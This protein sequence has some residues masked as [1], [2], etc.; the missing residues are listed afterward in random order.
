MRQYKN[1]IVKLLAITLMLPLIGL[2]CKGS[3]TIKQ[4]ELQRVTLE[5]WRVFDEP[6]DFSDIITEFRKS[7]PHININVRKFRLDEYENALLRALAE[8]RGP[9]IVSIHNTWVNQYKNVIT[10]MPESITLPTTVTD[11]RQQTIMLRSQASPSL[12]DIRNNF[13]DVVVDDVIRDG[14]VYGLPLSVDT[15]ALYY[16]KA[17]LTRENI[18]LPAATW[19]D[20]K[21][22]VKLLTIQDKNGNFVQ[23]GAALG[24]SRNINRAP[25]I[26]S[27]LM[28]QNGTEMVNKSGRASFN[29]RP[30]SITDRSI[31]PG[32]DALQFYTDFASPAKEVYTWNETMPEALDAFTAQKSAYFF[33]YSYHMPLIRSL[34]PGLDFGIAPLP[35][36]AGTQASVNFANY[37]VES[38]TAQSKHQNEAWAFVQFAA[39]QNQVG[40]FLKRADKPTALRT[41]IAAQRESGDLSVFA[42]QIL[43][44]QSWYRGTNAAASEEAFRVMIDQVVNGE[45]T[46]EKAVTIAAQKINETL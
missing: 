20:F 2:G 10:P 4:E 26:V 24:A 22:H 7:Y 12:R 42:N 45:Y 38:V 30:S 16:N 1:K 9:D 37:W 3:G 5:Y 29:A 8:G 36:I 11:G 39:S 13:V 19:N 34:A 44:A 35:Q 41:L 28:M 43:T 23:S 32:R 25:D 14:N 21:E 15:L 18:P 33:G 40:S 31:L 17:M 46:A 27:I 6:D